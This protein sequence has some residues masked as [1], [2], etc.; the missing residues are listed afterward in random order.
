[1]K[2]FIKEN[3]R[4]LICLALVLVIFTCFFLR[5]V[6]WQIREGSYYKENVATA[7]N[8]RLTSSATRGEILDRNGVALKS[9]KTTYNVIIDK[10]FI[11]DNLTENQ[12][13]EELLTLFEKTE[14]PFVDMLPIHKDENGV[15]QFITAE[16]TKEHRSALNYLKSEDFL[17]LGIYADAQEYI[18]ELY[19]RY[20]LAYIEDENFRRDMASV[21]FNMERTL[22]SYSSPYTIAEN[23][24]EKMMAIISELSQEKPCIDISTT[25]VRYCEDGTLMPHILGNTGALTAEEYEEYKDKGYSYDDTIG[26]FGIEAAMEDYLRGE[27]GVKTIKKT[28][29]GAQTGDVEIIPANPGNNVYLTID[30]DLQAVANEALERNV[31]DAREWGI[32]QCKLTGDTLLGEDCVAGAVV[33]LDVRDF[34]VLAAA[35]YPSYDLNQYSNS[36]YYTSLIENETLPLYDRAFM[37]SFAPGSVVKPSVALGALEEEII[38]E[39]TPVTCTKRYD[40]YPD[41]V[42]NCMG[43]HGD[44]DVTGAV[45]RSCNYFFAEV[46][47][48][49]GID[50]M[51]LYMEK[52]GLGVKT[53]LEI[54]ESTGFLAGRDSINWVPGNTVQA[55]IGQSDNTFTPVQLATYCA[56]IAN[57][58]VRL[59]THLISK[60]TSYD[61]TE[62]VLEN[63][64][65]NAEVVEDLNLTPYNMTVV[66]HAMRQVVA[67]E[68]GTAHNFFGDY[69]VDIAAKTGTAENT[70]SDHTAFICY[71][72]YDD[73]QV[74]IAVVIEHGA[75]GSFSMDVAKSLLDA[76]F[77]PETLNTEP[78]TTPTEASYE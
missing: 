63:T 26:K 37:G 71:A 57:D 72:P 49:L 33:M 24:D 73:P 67:N 17:G 11:P 29:A 66:Q 46:G 27:G 75:R 14:T 52:L 70:G 30:R 15:Y 4:A 13:I 58:G 41:N 68:S 55:A 20:D 74:A 53:G 48:R 61:K 9:N 43:T 69:P 36:D 60:I 25:S 8:Y 10:L 32:A 39:Y 64:P 34:S 31:N 47:R 35:T 38:T 23:I 12:I 59:R 21:R 22:Y 1:M 65:E 44:L 76:Y 16:D 7:A 42:V 54:N 77:F 28:S 50:T 56:T 51:A 6:N 5:L 18:N 3:T 62:V 40:Y 78:S 2:N 19:E 45:T